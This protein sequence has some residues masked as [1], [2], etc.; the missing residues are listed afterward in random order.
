MQKAPALN[1]A[2]MWP[3]QIGAVERLEKSIREGRPRALIQMATGSGKTYTAIAA[4]Y[5]LIKF[6]GAR[7]VLFLVDRG[8]L[9]RQAHKEFQAYTPPDDGRKFTELY[10]V[11]RLASNKIDPVNRVV[12]PG[13]LRVAKICHLRTPLETPTCRKW[14]PARFGRG[15]SNKIEV[16]AGKTMRKYFCGRNYGI[17][18]R[19]LLMVVGMGK[20]AR[21]G[22]GSLTWL[23]LT[24]ALGFIGCSGTKPEGPQSVEEAASPA[25]NDMPVKAWKAQKP[26]APKRFCVAV[27]I[28]DY[29]NYEWAGFGRFRNAK[30]TH[31]SLQ[32]HH[33]NHERN[34]TYVRKDS[35]VGAELWEIVKDGETHWM[36][37]E[38][39]YLT[40]AQ[41]ADAST[42]LE[43]IV[44]KSGC[45]KLK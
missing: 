8:N 43:S 37:L 30:N 23:L 27:E 33:G 10:N 6:G 12:R 39:S 4:L 21:M 9:G 40:N 18:E 3:A 29:F 24:L 35:P 45:R 16:L 22:A 14:A 5:R 25:Y 28:D 11:T 36:Q 19:R 2:G 41:D 44:N 15:A 20:G 38:I 7:R 1:S 32:L 34:H 26:T 17:G 42:I 13:L 31:H